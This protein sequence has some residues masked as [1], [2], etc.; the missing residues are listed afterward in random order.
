M[1]APYDE[2]TYSVIVGISQE[3]AN[4]VDGYDK[5]EWQEITGNG[6]DSVL[7]CMPHVLASSSACP[8]HQALSSLHRA[9]DSLGV[10]V[11]HNGAHC[12]QH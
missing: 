1:V 8:Q 11:R 2:W 4:V 6:H 3:G 10:G 5:C 7:S 12:R 9:C